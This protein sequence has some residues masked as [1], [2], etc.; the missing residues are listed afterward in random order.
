LA[1]ALW[2][3]GAH[4]KGPQV[5]AQTDE[6]PR[7]PDSG[8][9]PASK[10]ESL[11]EEKLSRRID[12]EYPETPLKQVLE[13]LQERTEIQIYVN[14][15][16]IDAT[17]LSLDAPITINLK[18][19]RVD[20]VLDLV[21]EQAGDQ[22]LAYVERDGILIVSTADALSGASEV[23]VYNCRDLLAM[24]SPVQQATG[25]MGGWGPAGGMMLPGMMPGGG[26]VGIG[27][28]DAGESPRNQPGDSPA[29]PLEPNEQPG[30]KP[31]IRPS[32]S[33]PRGTKSAP[34]SAGEPAT[35]GTPELSIPKGIAPQF[36]GG[37]PAG[38]AASQ[39]GAGMPAMAMG[40]SGMGGMGGGGM[41]SQSRN[42]EEVR[43]ER[44]MHLIT[45]AVKP[46]SWQD[47]G[48]F[49]TI[50]EYRG[51]IVINH[52]SRTH[53]EVENVLKMLREAAGLPPTG[54]AGGMIDGSM[55][56][57]AGKSGGLF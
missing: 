8:P 34:K 39:A 1:I 57:R 40:G 22:E 26:G 41:S 50:S 24:V 6:K 43:A 47:M 56:P 30:G 52:N 27:S 7:K 16:A 42:E 10:K 11:I 4:V 12:A 13:D 46:D 25:M 38:A 44:L 36:G 14:R 18:S 31:I 2:P 9:K 29:G 49:G 45:T 32:G 55:A 21:L 33:I 15:K 3:D 20:T 35:D 17:G 37:A 5:I 23:K 19:V 28:P 51:L 53:K 54:P 48:G